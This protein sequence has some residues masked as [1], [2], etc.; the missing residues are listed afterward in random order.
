MIAF[1]LTKYWGV[2]FN[3][4]NN[5]FMPDGDTF[6]FIVVGSGSAGAIVAARLSEIPQFNVLLVE[7][8]GDPP[9]TSVV[10][11]EPLTFFKILLL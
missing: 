7:A 4:N 6:D 10:C 11:M 1:L 2:I 8:G 3:P 9:V 5:N